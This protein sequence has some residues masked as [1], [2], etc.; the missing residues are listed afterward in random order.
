MGQA[1]WYA[2]PFLPGNRQ[3]HGRFPHCPHC[4]HFPGTLLDSP[5]RLCYRIEI[6]GKFAP[7]M[8]LPARVEL[9][10]LSAMNA[11]ARQ[12][13]GYSLSDFAGLGMAD[14]AK[15]SRV[16]KV[17]WWHES[18]VDWELQNPDR[19]MNECAE[20]FNTTP[21]WLSSIRNSDAFKSYRQ[22]RMQI[23]QS[24]VS[25]S[26]ID[27]VE[28][29]ASLT[30]D[31]LQERVERERAA[32][33]LDS[34]LDTAKVALTALGFGGGPKGGNPVNVQINNSNA[35]ATPPVTAVDSNMLQVARDRLRQAQSGGTLIEQFAEPRLPS[36][37]QAVP[38]AE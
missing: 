17:S 24:G 6:M 9:G 7:T 14:K 37:A 25:R 1:V 12:R 15:V 29:L 26:I 31:V 10:E 20:F 3:P 18:I 8:A 27:K 30:L 34:V 32:I 2:I 38:A 36:P 19:T 13:T 23:H 28:G 5:L 4:P 16:M 11:S 21:A 22:Y 35:Q 33:A